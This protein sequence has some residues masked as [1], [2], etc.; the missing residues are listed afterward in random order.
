[1]QEP[2]NNLLEK[3][4]PKEA[5]RSVR[6]VRDNFKRFRPLCCICIPLR[7]GV[8]LNACSTLVLSTMMFVAKKQFEESTRVVGGGY[9]VVSRTIIFFIEVTGVFWAICGIIGAYQCEYSYVWLYNLYQWTRIAAWLLMFYFD[10]PTLWYCELWIVDIKGAHEQMGW[11]PTVYDI[12]MNGGCLRERTEFMFCSTIGFFIFFY[13]ALENQRFQDE[14]EDEPPYLYFS[15]DIPKGSFFGQCNGERS[16]LRNTED[17][18]PSY[19]VNPSY[20]VTS[21]NA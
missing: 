5:L 15:K 4:D 12:A 11:N 7:L 6:F 18:Y 20:G 3:A 10:L 19:G 9:T 16:L 1:M 2:S 14:L 21:T 17:A 13:L 8:F